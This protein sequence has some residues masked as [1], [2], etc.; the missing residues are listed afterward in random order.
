MTTKMPPPPLAYTL[1]EIQPAAGIGI[2]KIKE[3]IAAGELPIVKIGKRTLV[4]H[5]DLHALLARNRV[6][7]GNGAAPPLPGQGSGPAPP[8]TGE[9]RSRRVRPK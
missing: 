1:D 5:E 3:L 7:R 2:S 9:I 4:M 8:P 6:T